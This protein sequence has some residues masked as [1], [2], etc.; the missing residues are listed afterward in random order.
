[1]VRNALLADLDA[2]MALLEGARAWH[3]EQGL[4]V[5]SGFDRRELAADIARRCVF[6]ADACATVTLVEEDLVWPT[7]AAALYVHR[8]ASARRGMGAQL[9]TWAGRLALERRKSCLRLETWAENRR[10]RD[11]YERHGFRHVT[12]RFYPADAAVPQ[13]YRGTWKSL[14]QRDL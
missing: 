5:W 9:L 13:D 1:M 3:R 2:V 6:L 12:D 14:Y 8:L 7:A 10:M 11:Y 4:P